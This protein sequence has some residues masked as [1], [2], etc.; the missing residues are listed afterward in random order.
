[1]KIVFDVEILCYFMTSHQFSM[2]SLQVIS[3]SAICFMNHR[4]DWGACGEGRVGV[5]EGGRAEAAL[6]IFGGDSRA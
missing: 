6:E 3:W 4:G 5:G 1:M 2:L